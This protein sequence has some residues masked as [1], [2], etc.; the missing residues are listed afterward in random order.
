[1]SESTTDDAVLLDIDDEIATITLNRPDMRNALTHEVSMALIDTLDEV[2]ESD[3]RALVVT[4]AGGAF[5]AGG[6]INSMTERLSGDMPTHEA[7]RHIRQATSRAIA[8]VAT[9][10]LPTFAKIDGVAFGAGANLALACDIQLASADS[11]ISFGFKQVGL[12]VDTGTSYFL[13]RIVGMNTA[14]ELVFTGEL[15]DAD[16]A[17][18]LGLFNRVYDDIGEADE[19]IGEIAN[20][21]TVALAHSKETL[22]QGFEQSLDQAMTREA[23]HQAAV[24]ETHDHREGA[25]AFMGKREPEFEGR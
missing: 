19:F 22:A 25:E 20:G 10:Y 2:E 15:V 24:F 17:E 7:V 16:R 11:K 9:F 14:K 6:D 3:A 1:M 5:S 23:Q 18:D 4:G 12:A 13:P 8:R 21:P